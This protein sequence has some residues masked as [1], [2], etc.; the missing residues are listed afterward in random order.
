MATYQKLKQQMRQLQESGKLPSTLSDAERAD[1]AY[2]NAVIENEAV[3]REMAA[4]AVAHRHAA[5]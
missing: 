3:T 5:K 1:W 2:G 4:A